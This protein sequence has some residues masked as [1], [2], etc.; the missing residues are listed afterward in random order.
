MPIS[1]RKEIV[2]SGLPSEGI[3][4]FG[5]LGIGTRLLG[6]GYRL[7]VNLMFVTLRTFKSITNNQYPTTNHQY[8]IPSTQQPVSPSRQ[9]ARNH[10]A[11]SFFGKFFMVSPLKT[12]KKCRK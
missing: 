5:C 6:I 8:P 1:L 10:P 11:T 12:L 7:L 3:F 2:P 4:C 9:A